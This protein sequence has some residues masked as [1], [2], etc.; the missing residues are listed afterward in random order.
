MYYVGWDIYKT[1]GI[2]GLYRGGTSSWLRE[3]VPGG[4]FLTTYEM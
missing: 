2:R 4:V 1:K 3:G